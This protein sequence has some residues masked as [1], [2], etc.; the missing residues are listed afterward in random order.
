VSYR[1]MPHLRLY[2]GWGWR[3]FT[4]DT[5]LAG[6]DYDVENTGYMGGLL[7]QHPL[8]GS[9]WGW[10]RGGPVY[11]HIELE[12]GAD[13]AVDSGHEAGWELGGGLRVPLTD[14]LAVLPGVRY[15]S[16]S[17]DLELNGAQVPVDLRYI[18]V[19]VGV[20][21]SFGSLDAVGVAI[22]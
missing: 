5:P 16:L 10:V 9:L 21:W 14:R 15:R 8:R 6:G 4:T 20:A 22:R 18:A 7:F 19:D 13:I 1:L 3:H 17:A 12:Q 11:E 2:A